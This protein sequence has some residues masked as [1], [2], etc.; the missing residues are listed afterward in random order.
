MF[1]PRR[2]AAVALFSLVSLTGCVVYD[3][4]A[5]QVQQQPA[6]FD[7]SWDAAMG[8]MQD[9]GV[10]VGNADRGAGMIQGRKDG[11]DVT[12]RLNRQADGSVRVEINAKGGGNDQG[13]AN[14]V[15]A[16]YERRMGR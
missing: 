14:V 5:Y 3:P 11:S 16:A 8:A 4:Y 12:L 15:N 2:L 6:S 1:A 7:R 10:N 9:A 13:V